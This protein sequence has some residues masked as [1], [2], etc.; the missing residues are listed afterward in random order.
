V[1]KILLR[2]LSL[3]SFY[4]EKDLLTLVRALIHGSA[5]PFSMFKGLALHIWDPTLL[6]KPVQ[7]Q[8]SFEL[9]GQD[10]TV[11]TSMGMT[12]LSPQLF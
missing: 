7:G 1:K 3:T 4:V 8:N 12:F 9:V 5:T 6:L 11:L 10:K 2:L